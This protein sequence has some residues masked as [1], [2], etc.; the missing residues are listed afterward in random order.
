MQHYKK[1]KHVLKEYAL[2][3]QLLL[4]RSSFYCKPLSFCTY[5]L[6]TQYMIDFGSTEDKEDANAV[7][8]HILNIEEYRELSISILRKLQVGYYP[9]LTNC[10]SQQRY[11]KRFS[12]N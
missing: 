12:A 6:S 4:I 3:L 5:L 2:N 7:C 11:L 8:N 9:I 10:F 1:V